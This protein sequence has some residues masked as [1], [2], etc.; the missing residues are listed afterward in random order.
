MGYYPGTDDHLAFTSF[1]PSPLTTG[2]YSHT[3]THFDAV[4]VGRRPIYIT[5][6]AHSSQNPLQIFKLSSPPV[7]IKSDIN[8]WDNQLVDG[9]DPNMDA[10]FQTSTTEIA[11]YLSIG[12]HCPISYVRWSV[13]DTNGTVVSDYLDALLPPHE[14]RDVNNEVLLSTDQ[15]QLYN[16]ETYRVLVQARDMTGEVFILRSNGVTVTTHNLV[17]GIVLDGPNPDE[18]LSY[19][20]PTEYLSASWT[21]FGDGTP[22]QEIAYYEVAAGSNLGH[23]NTRTD[24]APF[25][26][27]GLNTNHTFANLDLIPDDVLYSVTVRATS[28]SGATVE[29]TSNGIRVGLTHS[30]SPGTIILPHFSSNTTELWV[31]WGEFE[32]DVPIRSYEW[33]VGDKYFT[34]EQ[35]QT[36]CVDYLSNFEEEFEVLPFTNIGLSTSSFLSGLNLSNNA[37]YYV[38]VRAT[39]E[40]NKC[41]A[42]MSSGMFVDLTPPTAPLQNIRAGPYE[43]LIGIEA[44]SQHIT[45]VRSDQDISVTWDN[46]ID[47]ESGI[48]YYEIALFQQETCG[49]NDIL[50]P[51]TDYVNTG[52]DRS[53]V[54]K[55]PNLEVQAAYVVKVRATNMA[56]ISGGAYSEPIMLDSTEVVPGTVKDGMDWEDN[57]VFQSDLSTL[58]GVFTHAKLE[59][60]YPGVLV[61][62]DPC[63]NT[64]FYSLSE[65][66]TAWTHLTPNTIIGIDSPTLDYSPSQTN[67]TSEGLRISAVYDGGGGI[68]SGAH[69]T[70]VDLSRGGVVSIGIQAALGS[71]SFDMDLQQQ[72]ITSVVFIDTPVPD[73][74]VDYDESREYVYPTSP[75]FA[76]VG[77]QIHHGYNDTEQK[78]VLWGNSHSPLVP[79]SHVT[80]Y[81]PTVDLTRVHKYTLDFQSEQLDTDS[82]RWV[83]LYIDDQLVATLHS[84]PHLSNTTH[85]NLHVFNRDGFVPVIPDPLNPPLVQALFA[86]VTIPRER[87]HTCDFGQPFY[88]A[89]SPIVEFSVGIGSSPGLTDVLELEVRPSLYQCYSAISVL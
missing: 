57:V 41:L 53:F 54:F 74:L 29:S 14:G 1:T 49:N 3:I 68:L 10:E 8:E 50:I 89:S 82:E 58:S 73:V 24:I 59:S 11:A 85:L 20:E 17:P 31:Y 36:M 40:A 67:T 13:E 32:S 23:P 65:N 87:G 5:V 71:S 70:E 78:V 15:V 69:Q 45:F 38:V 19:Q 48:E 81:I 16:E 64:T 51:L 60:Q 4:S 83:D 6:Q 37:S 55:Q 43:S 21:D 7:Y 34:T 39:D 30:I 77:L 84:I 33:A 12:A 42:V 26:N 9:T 56:G 61:Q 46:F 66:S 62:N 86:N 27:V 79:V 80:H 52:H 25:T 2:T 88:S 44:N 76:A 72:S 18:D 28:V 22:Q 63:P 35:L 75:T 47:R